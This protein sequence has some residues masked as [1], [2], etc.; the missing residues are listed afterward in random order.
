MRIK[1]LRSW[2]V[3]RWNEA[4]K[5]R[6]RTE[7]HTIDDISRMLHNNLTNGD[8]KKLI[9]FTRL[10]RDLTF[11]VHRRLVLSHLKNGYGWELSQ[12]QAQRLMKIMFGVDVER[13]YW[14]QRLDIPG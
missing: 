5:Q 10:D 11:H 12:D 6:T 14:G 1:A 2:V 8:L 9:E 7:E 3:S 13:D 4:N